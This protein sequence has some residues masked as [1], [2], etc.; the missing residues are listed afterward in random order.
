MLDD[1]GQWINGAIGK[2]QGGGQYSRDEVGTSDRGEVTEANVVS[3]LGRNLIGNE[4]SERGL[5]DSAGSDKRN[6]SETLEPVKD[7][8]GGLISSNRQREQSR[9]AFRASRNPGVVRLE[10]GVDARDEPIATTRHSGNEL[11]DLA[12]IFQSL[13]EQG[14][15]RP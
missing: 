5:S 13:S 7:R 12:R 2:A 10:N 8:S 3:G 15:L 14:D 4:Y 11:G 6:K 1:A 9:K